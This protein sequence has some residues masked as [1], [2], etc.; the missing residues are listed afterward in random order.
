MKQE[1]NR[2]F[3]TVMI[4]GDKFEFSANIYLADALQTYDPDSTFACAV[5][6]QFVGKDKYK[7][8][9]LKQN[10]SIDVLVPIVGG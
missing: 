4:N 3:I 8:T 1:N 2:P 9:L 5:N 10:D 6:G 7:T